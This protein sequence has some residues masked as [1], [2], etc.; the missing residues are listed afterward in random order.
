MSSAP[1]LSPAT[2]LSEV[3]ERI[4]DTS[5]RISNAESANRISL[6]ALIASLA[7]MAWLVYA[8]FQRQ[9]PLW[10]F[11]LPIPAAIAAGRWHG[12]N[13]DRWLRLTRLRKFHE[14]RE[15]R[16]EDRWHGEGFTGEEFRIPDHV[17]SQ[18]LHILGSGSM[19]ELMATARTGIGRRYLAAYL[20]EPVDREQIEL[21]QQSVREL[22]PQTEL[23]E[24]VNLLGKFSFQESDWSVFAEWLAVRPAPVPAALRI[25]AAVVSLL[26]AGVVIAGFSSS[27]PVRQVIT[28][29]VPLFAI[30][31]TIAW[32]HRQH[33]KVVNGAAARVGVD[34]GVVR[35]GMELMGTQSFQSTKLAQIQQFLNNADA[36]RA[37]HRLERLTNLLAQCEKPQFDLFAQAVI[38]RTQLSFAIE[39]WKEKHGPQLKG[40][41][42]AWGEF[43]V[44]TAISGYA[45]EHPGDA[46][47]EFLDG[48][49]RFEATD[50]GHP[51]IAD[52]TCVRNNVTLDAANRFYIISGSNMAGKSTL[53][54]S[55]GLNAVLAAAGAPV[56][57]SSLRLTGFRVI[58]SLSIVD[59]ILE[60][61]SK[62][63]AEVDRVR[64]MLE[65]ARRAPV[66]FLI[67]E[68]L[69]G[70]N[71]RDRRFA[72]EAVIRS[73]IESGAIGALSTHDLALTEIALI[74]ALAGSNVHM[75][76]APGGGPM[77]FDYRMKP[78]VTTE[79]NALA[80][81]AM[82][83]V[84]AS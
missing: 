14:S 67:D 50:L 56:R 33:T 72:S 41:L 17:Y 48:P 82:M 16:L 79:T 26:L 51:L 64:S 55:I 66:L 63:L 70:T 4:R 81:A 12:R 13:R 32:I 71:S 39:R 34:I 20:L 44:L 47:P 42:A 75:G 61:K 21:R 29:V 65:H 46:F 11:L 25:L 54:R 30:L 68:I 22:I 58:A 36:A 76:S 43:E 10:A 37:L 24:K 78:G 57:A 31:M 5:S 3:Q 77:D 69:S 8:G 38:L 23:R 45:W 73:L 60:G 19:F 28:A 74:P 1:R 2:R 49:P 53:L 6:Q 62:F 35:E 83:G 52:S 40:W 18:D 27:L 80:I 59:S 7:V 84:L 15:A 9:V